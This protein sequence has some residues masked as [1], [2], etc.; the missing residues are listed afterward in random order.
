MII[1]QYTSIR[2]LKCRDENQRETIIFIMGKVVYPNNTYNLFIV[3]T[4][5]SQS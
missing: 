3:Y 2:S 4:P 1:V 5:V